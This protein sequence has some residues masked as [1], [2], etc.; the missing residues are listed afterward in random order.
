MRLSDIMMAFDECPPYPAE[1]DY[2]KRSV[3]RTSRWAERCLEAHSRPQDQGL[4]ELFKAESLKIYAVK[5]QL[6]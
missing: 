2:L 4:L 3:E 1:Y 5:V 6:I